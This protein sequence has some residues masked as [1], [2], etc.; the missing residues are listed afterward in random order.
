[1]GADDPRMA[2]AADIAAA[3][4]QRELSVRLRLN[5]DFRKE[6]LWA[7]VTSDGRIF[8]GT[9][10]LRDGQGAYVDHQGRLMAA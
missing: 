6:D 7:A 3:F 9:P 10:L 2:R 1:M 5:P 4:I 8:I